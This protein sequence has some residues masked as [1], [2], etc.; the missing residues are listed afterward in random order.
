MLF[1]VR[2]PGCQRRGWCPCPRCVRDLVPPE[3]ASIAGATTTHVLFGHEGAGRDFIHAVKFGGERAIVGWLGE[4]LASR[5]RGFNIDLVTW[6]PTSSS[7]R[8]ERGFDQARILA[9]SV[10]R[11]LGVPSRS[12]LVRIGHRPQEGKGR[13]ARLEG[14]RFEAKRSGTGKRILIVD[15]VLTTGASLQAAVSALR[16][17]GHGSVHAAAL[18]RTAAQGRSEVADAA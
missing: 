10:A 17:A 6:A 3:P 18:S 15:D 5:V 7:R 16:A 12:L 9:S 11:E 2:C 4:A 14:P 8:R 1:D 13:E